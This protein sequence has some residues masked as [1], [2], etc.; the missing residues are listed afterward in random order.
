MWLEIFDR[1]ILRTVVY[2]LE[3]CTVKFLLEFQLDFIKQKQHKKNL[4]SVTFLLLNIY[5]LAQ[6]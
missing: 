6:K 2:Y 1:F 5:Y 3:L 4:K